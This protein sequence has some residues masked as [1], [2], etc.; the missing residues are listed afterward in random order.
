MTR[1]TDEAVEAGMTSLGLTRQELRAE[2]SEMI[3]NAYAEGWREAKRRL[4]I[5]PPALEIDWTR[6]GGVQITELWGAES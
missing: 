2:I 4:D 1:I 6:P 3:R 5:D